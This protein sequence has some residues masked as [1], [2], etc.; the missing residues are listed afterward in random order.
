MC[1]LTGAASLWIIRYPDIII[2][3]H[4]ANSRSRL[5]RLFLPRQSQHPLEQRHP[6]QLRHLPRKLNKVTLC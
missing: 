4:L 5:L 6:D 3:R 1:G 2:W